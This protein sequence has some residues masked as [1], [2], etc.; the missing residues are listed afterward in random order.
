MAG[1]PATAAAAPIALICTHTVR[2]VCR[3]L[4]RQREQ[5]ERVQRKVDETEAHVERAGFILSG[6]KSIGGAVY[7]HL[8][9]HK[10]ALPKDVIAKREAERAAK[11][12]AG[13]SSSSA[14]AVGAA[15]LAAAAAASSTTTSSAAG[16]SAG[17]SA[18]TAS[19]SGSKARDAA[20]AEEDAL[21]AMISTNLTETKHIASTM[22]AELDRQDG[23]L[24]DLTT[25]V[26]RTGAKL[27]AVDKTT[28]RLVARG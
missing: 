14:A 3:E 20:M 10:P 19:T 15:A 4:E 25:S 18:S 12:E 23:M 1:A 11:R 5:I 8:F 21:L 16:G 17:V 2:C 7:N 22:G 26:D 28:T 24:D 9:A 13:G 6:M 27:K